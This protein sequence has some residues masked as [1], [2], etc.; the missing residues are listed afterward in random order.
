MTMKL[1]ADPISTTCRP[2]LLFIADAGAPV[3]FQLIELMKGAHMQP[4]F[5]AI[6]PSHAVPVLQDDEMVLTESSAILKYLADKVGSPLYPKD[7][8]KR[9]KVNSMMDWLNTGLYRD[10]GYGFC[11]PQV[12]PHMKH[13]HEVA[14][15]ATINAGRERTKKWLNILD[16]DLIGPKNN[17]L[18]G[19]ELTIADYFGIGIFSLADLMRCDLSPWPNIQRWLKTMRARPSWNKVQEEF[20][21]KFVEPT[22]DVP[23]VML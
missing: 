8:K 20:N 18:V 4:E 12:F 16:K 5:I 17:Y 22:K 9:A 1:Y 2:I 21:A 6:N 10:F 13:E 11:Y 15:T 7:L 14:Q 19:N 3:E 23:F